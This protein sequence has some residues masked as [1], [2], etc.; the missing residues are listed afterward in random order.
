MANVRAKDRTEDRKRTTNANKNRALRQEALREFLSKKCTLQHILK[1]LLIIEG[2]DPEAETF[3]NDLAKYKVANEQ[4]LKLLGKYLPDLKN[5]ELVGQDGE[6]LTIEIVRF[7]SN[8]SEQ[9]AS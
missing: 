9:L 1:N 8:D 6:K 4:R 7:A 5:T 3:Q 2:L